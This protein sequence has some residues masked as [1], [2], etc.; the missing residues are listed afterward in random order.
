MLKVADGEERL[1]RKITMVVRT[2]EVVEGV[3]RESDAPDKEHYDEEWV[4]LQCT[5]GKPLVKQNG[6]WKVLQDVASLKD[7]LQYALWSQRDNPRFASCI[8]DIMLRSE[9]PDGALV[10]YQAQVH[11]SQ[12]HL[13][14]DIIQEPWEDM[15]GYYRRR[16]NHGGKAAPQLR[17]GVAPKHDP[18]KAVSSST[19]QPDALPGEQLA[20]LDVVEHK[21]SSDHESAGSSAAVYLDLVPHAASDTSTVASVA[22]DELHGTC[23]SGDE[24]ERLPTRKRQLVWSDESGDENV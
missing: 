7:W 12:C 3:P 11:S 13:L 18:R 20:A 14:W 2:W 17:W 1:E 10:N 24:N 22:G 15:R 5:R 19:E 23:L 16:D 9:T 8:E 4:T 6:E 21:T